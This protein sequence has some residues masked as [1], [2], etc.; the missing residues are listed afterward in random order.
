[1]KLPTTVVL[2]SKMRIDCSCSHRRGGGSPQWRNRHV[3][4]R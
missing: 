1:V 2:V 4:P 3:A